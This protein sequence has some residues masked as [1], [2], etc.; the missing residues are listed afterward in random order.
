VSSTEGRRTISVL[1]VDLVPSGDEPVEDAVAD[2]VVARARREIRLLGGALEEPGGHLAVG[3]FGAPVA[4]ADAI[5][6]AVRAALR[7]ADA[8]EDLGRP[9]V[10]V[11]AGV[12]TGSY[13]SPGDNR[14]AQMEAERAA[15]ALHVHDGGVGGVVVDRAT[16]D[17]TRDLFEYEPVVGDAPSWVAMVARGRYGVDFELNLPTPF[18]G[19]DHELA[20]LTDVYARVLLESAPHI[21]TIVGAAGTGKSRLLSEFWSVLDARP[22]L[23]Y[24]R[25][26]R[27][28]GDGGGITM[29]A[30]GEIVK[31]QAGILESDNMRT[32]VDKLEVTLR[33]FLP[34]EEE[35]R[36]TG[37]LLGPL[38]GLVPDDPAP[39]PRSATFP[40]W[41]RFLHAVA[42]THPM[43]LVF[44]DL[45]L[46]DPGTLAFVRFLADHTDGVPMLVVCTARL[47]LFDRDRSWV[48][49]G[50]LRSTT[51]QL[52]P[53]S[54]RDTR[55]LIASVGGPA[56][57]P[58]PGNQPLV[59]LEA[60]GGNPLYVEAYARLLEEGGRGGSPRPP[61]T[62][63][64]LMTERLAAL[65]PAHRAL[66]EDA[67]VIGKVFWRGAL[68]AVG[69]RGPREV[70]EGLAELTRREL[71][72][73][74][75][76][77]S[78]AGQTEHAFWHLVIRD[79]VLEHMDP[80]RRA[81]AHLAAADWLSTV[82]GDR[83]GDHAEI[84]AHHTERASRADP[85]GTREAAREF[86]RLA[87]DRAALLDPERAA[88][89]Y[90]RA[91]ALHPAESPERDELGRRAQASAAAA[92]P[93]GAG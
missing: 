59:L 20:L 88:V 35:A 72:R 60:A 93:T 33:Q 63:M 92:G 43:V 83:F 44:E 3:V 29:W 30:P 1:V 6:R 66:L 73:P 17:A 87:A 64:A 48:S 42:A 53:L 7:V 61:A 80:A 25:Q 27:S 15:A 14:V 40:A 45:H 19:R 57:A 13:P 75:R 23:V 31:S 55:E 38:A 65:G 52:G 67:A 5:E 41:L 26:G 22:E 77:S 70:D 68:E 51:I 24:W 89:L 50:S 12:H 28:L 49:T 32:A 90:E 39:V 34:D 71:I 81:A 37:E 47:E 8:V 2:E 86:L 58:A 18:T 85:T 82:A 10:S 54:G 78:V 9:G 62:L 84:L 69:G 76:R 11:H 4:R 74:A 36:R 91:A 46:A 56:D 16:H 21:V 79:A